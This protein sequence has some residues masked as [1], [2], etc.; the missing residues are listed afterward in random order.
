MTEWYPRVPYFSGTLNA[1]TRVGAASAS[2]GVR[3][4]AW[5]G[6]AEKGGTHPVSEYSQ[7]C[8]RKDRVFRPEPTLVPRLVEAIVKSLLTFVGRG[9]RV[10]AE[11]F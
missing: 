5:L 10:R 7:V 1:T 4:A 11:L 8:R 2:N 9:L 6:G 3:T